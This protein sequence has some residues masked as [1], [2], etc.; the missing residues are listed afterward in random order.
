MSRMFIDP[1]TG[2]M[3]D[4]RWFRM[5]NIDLDTVIEAVKIDDGDLAFVIIPENIK[6]MKVRD[7][8]VTSL[9]AQFTKAVLLR[10][11]ESDD[12]EERE[13]LRETGM[14]VCTAMMSHIADAE[15]EDNGENL[16]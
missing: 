13:W 11:H 15:R 14:L 9:I 2:E 3:H 6:R 1:A 8:V 16:H 4:E 5:Q 7:A 12:E 10:M